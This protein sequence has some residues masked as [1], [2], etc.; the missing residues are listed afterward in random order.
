MTDRQI[1]KFSMYT[2][3]DAILDAN[4]A[5]FASLAA[6]VTAHTTLKAKIAAI[7]SASEQQKTVTLGATPDKNFT[8]EALRTTTVTNAGL[9]F[10]YAVST[11]DIILQE[12][13]R[14]TYTDLKEL[15]DDELAER[16]QT[17]HD[18]ANT[19][20]ASLAPFGITAAVLTSYQ[21]LIDSYEVKAPIPR[22]KTSE[23]VA[24]TEQVKTLIKETDSLLKN[25]VDKLMLNFKI[26]EP[27]F[28][29]T[30]KA[31][32]EIIDIGHIPTQASGEITDS[33][34]GEELSGVL[35]EVIGFPY[36]T[37]SDEDGEYG[38]KIPVPGTYS[39]RFSKTGYQTKTIDDVVITLGQT[40][41]L[42]V[43]LIANPA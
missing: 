38:V 41:S 24:L 9:L 16:A 3:V 21:T 32:R 43:Q 12:L 5:L 15:K 18:N 33:V 2:V 36:S 34:T 28:Y 37:N 40:T 1:A 25:T 29:N 8:R 13:S 27:E 30:Y 10:A 19:H 35:V 39:I 11:N 31:G 26:S 14:L 20:I 6:L 23:Q 17:I 7:S 22:A 42:D 4:S